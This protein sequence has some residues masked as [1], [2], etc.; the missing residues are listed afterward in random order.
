MRNL[1][2]LAVFVVLVLASAT[3]QTPSNPFE[4][5]LTIRSSDGSVIEAGMPTILCLDIKQSNGRSLLY[6]IR[7]RQLHTRLLHIVLIP[8]TYSAVLHVHLEDY[9]ALFHAYLA[10][11]HCAA[12]N[13]TLP[14]AG[15]WVVGVNLWA[16]DQSDMTTVSTVIDVT[17]RPAVAPFPL[18][19]QSQ[20]IV[21]P[22]PL[23]HGQSY[24]AAVQRSKLLTP[25]TGDLVID[26]QLDRDQRPVRAKECCPLALSV[27]DATTKQ[28]V[29]DLL[30]LLSL[31]AHLFLFHYNS[32]T[33]E[34]FF[35]HLH[36]HSLNKPASA[37]CSADGMHGMAAMAGVHEQH[38]HDMESVD[39]M[40]MSGGATAEQRF[41]SMV[42]ASG[43]KF[44]CAGRW[45]IVGQLR[46]GDTMNETSD[47]E[48][49]TVTM[50]VMVV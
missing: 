44:D 35:H 18:D 8:A 20:Q 45:M 27:F 17:G 14:S 33:N 46:K 7:L 36:A 38:M 3:A 42:E 30:P 19:T 21:Q 43:V 10:S 11:D 41:G 15:R 5:Q 28:P 13:V 29:V 6:P 34:Y 23:Q 24:T 2:S 22:L 1:T 49:L 40:V 9:P 37:H 16:V 32:S 47:G 39:G 48:L 50:D 31:P 25:Q 12:V 4:H 26:V